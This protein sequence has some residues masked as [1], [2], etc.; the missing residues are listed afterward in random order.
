[1][2]IGNGLISK[3]FKKLFNE[4]ENVII[5]ASGVSDSQ[6]TNNDNFLRENKLLTETIK[7]NT[8]KQIIYFSSIIVDFKSNPYY[9]HKKEMENLIKKM[10]KNYLIFRIPQ[11]IG[12]DGNKNN[13]INYL[14]EKI[15][16]KEKIIIYRDCKRSIMDI[17]DI[18]K[19]VNYCINKITNKIIYVSGIEKIFIIDLSKKIAYHLNENIIM[20]IKKKKENNNWVKLKSEIF[21]DFIN[22]SKIEPYGYTEKILKKYIK[23]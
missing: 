23:I 6:E 19:F 20:E 7:N 17:E 5:F 11:L 9:N 16:N 14:I 8:G 3:S 21:N 13:L 15:K 4:D 10:S 12:I 22:T 1:M 18:F 2:V